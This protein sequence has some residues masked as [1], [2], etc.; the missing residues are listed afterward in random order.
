MIFDKLADS[1]IRHAK[2]IVVVW[3]VILLCSAP[4]ALKAGEVMNYDMNDMGSD[5]S[6]SMQGMLVIEEHFP[7]SSTD[8]AAV[9][10]LVLHYTTP[11]EKAAAEGFAGWL[12]AHGTEYV[13]SDGKPLLGNGPASD[14]PYFMSM[15]CQGEDVENIGILLVGVVYNSEYLTATQGEEKVDVFIQNDTPSIREFV[16]EQ[17][18]AYAAVDPVVS[19]VGAYIT[20]S[21]AISHDTAAGAMEDI[22]KIDPFTV[23]LILILVGLF[24][25]SFVS[26]GAPPVTIGAAF[27]VVMALIFGLGQ[28]LEI[29]F[30]TE[31][32]LLV[33]MMGAGCDY[34]I[35]I[36]ARYREELRAGKSHH[37]ALHEAIKWAGESISISG[38]A[39]MIGFGTM[40]ICSI[41]F[42]STMGICLALGI[43]VALLAALTLIPAIIELV[44]DRIFWPT[45]MDAFQE[46]GKATRGWFAWCGRVGKRY[47]ES[48][49]RFSIKH[50]KAIVVAAVIA[51]VPCVYV[52]MEAETSYDMVGA[53]QNGDSGEGMDLIGEYAYQ[54]LMMPNYILFETS[55]PVATIT[56]DNVMGMGTITTLEWS[57]KLAQ[58]DLGQLYAEIHQDSNIAEVVGPFVWEDVVAETAADMNLSIATPVDRASNST[59]I[60]DAIISGSSPVIE[61]YIEGVVTTMR[62]TI[63]DLYPMMT[64]S[65]VDTFILDTGNVIDYNVNVMAGIIG[66]PFVQSADGSGDVTFLK[67]NYS[68]KDAAMSPLSMGTIDTVDGIVDDYVSAHS[69]IIANEWSTGTPAIMYDISKAVGEEFTHIEVL[70][71][72]LIMILLFLVMKS[73]TIPVRSVLTILMSIAWTLAIT[74][75]LFGSVLGAEVMW[76]IPLIL[77]VICLGLG[78][79]YDILLTTRIKENVHKGMS[80][81]D[82]IF[83]AVTHSGSVITVCG[84]IM[85]GAFGTLMLSSMLM[86]QEFGFA[87]CFAILVDALIVRTYIVPAVMHLLG[88]LN[89]KGPAFL[90]RL[91]NGSE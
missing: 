18:E 69:G 54:G 78:M 4:L 63:G 27:V 91:G 51:T 10:I 22:S 85:G 40:C 19:D 50:A 58:M 30:I 71:V 87:L 21:P 42:I 86:M 16:S 60:I 46:G 76:M 24:F 26:S 83:H 39:V 3:A 89:W 74:H 14:P 73:Y 55:A 17:K 82:A 44:G 29:F 23:L 5:D 25:R 70:V 90:K 72:I 37:D 59:A 57:E 47:F 80:N 8:V 84:L 11:A 20:G 13:D 9:P 49:A 66:G 41:S 33:A 45:R 15:G 64:P 6:E 1:I 67:I 61:P 88:D 31:M 56:V 62:T 53:M 34:C 81:D 68:T 52:L 7:G 79:D 2:L 36:I 77:L 35:F 48:S 32:L 12:N 43:L 75:V 65:M 38:L 28:F